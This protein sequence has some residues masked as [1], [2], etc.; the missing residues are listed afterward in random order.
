M[1]RWGES[2]RPVIRRGQVNGTANSASGTVTI[3]GQAPLAELWGYH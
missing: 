2:R 1:R 3:K